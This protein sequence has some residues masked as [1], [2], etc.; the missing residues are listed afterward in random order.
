MIKCEF[1]EKTN[2][3]ASEALNRSVLGP[4]NVKG[5][6]EITVVEVGGAASGGTGLYVTLRRVARR[7]S[8]QETHRS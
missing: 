8:V 6:G 1:E 4:G 7:R 5:I 3:P 2:P